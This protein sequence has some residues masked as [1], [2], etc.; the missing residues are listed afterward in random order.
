MNKKISIIVPCYNTEKYV[1][2]CLD[3]LI[4]QTY[5]NLEIIVVNDCSPGN[6]SEIVEEYKSNDDRIKIVNHKK[7]RGLFQARLSGSEIATG[8]YICFVDSDDYVDL[9]FY[10][11]MIF[12]A[13]KSKSDIVVCNTV[14]EERNRKFIY[15]LFKTGKT[16]LHE[17]EILDEYFKQEGQNYRWH[18]VWNKIYS[19]ELWKKCAPHYKIVDKHLIMTEDFM[20]STV[21]FSNAKK[22]TYNDNANYFYCSNDDASTS[23]SKINY[24]KAQKN[25]DDIVYSFEC[26]QNYLKKIKLFKKYKSNFINWRKLYADIWF[27]NITNSDMND[28][29]KEKLL[30]KLELLGKNNK[31]F[32]E[33]K[34]YSV[35]TNFNDKLLSLKK[36]IVNHDVISFDVFDTLVVRPFFEPV[37]LFRF[38]NKKY[39]ELFKSNGLLEFSTIRQNAERECRD[40]YYKKGIHEINL[41]Q[42]YDYIFEKYKLSKNKLNKIKQLEIE[43]EIRFCAKRETAYNLY[44]LARYLG[45]KVIITSD[46]YLSKDVIKKILQKNGYDYFDYYFVSNEYNKTKWTGELFDVV[47]TTINDN[48]LSYLHIGD[49]LQSDVESPRKLNFDAFHFP[50]T[51]D[52]FM[53]CSSTNI[54]NHC[55]RLFE[56]FECLHIDYGNYIDFLGNRCSMAIVANKFFDNPFVSFNENSDFN[57]DANFIGYYTLGMHTLA[58]TK[59][60]LDDVTEKSYDSLSFMARDGYIPYLAAKEMINLYNNKDLKMNYTYVSRKAIFPLS[61]NDFVDLYKF[62]EYYDMRTT[63]IEDILMLLKQILDLPNDYEKKLKENGYSKKQLLLT[64]DE[65]YNFMQFLYNNFYSIKKYKKNLSIAKKYFANEYNG[66]A[67]NFDIGYSGQPELVLSSILEKPIDTYFIHVNTDRGF[68]KSNYANYKLN[69]FYQFKPTFTGTLREYMI[70]SKSQS[71]I[72][73]YEK[74]D[75]VYPLLDEREIYSYF[76]TKILEEIQTGCIDFVKD[77]CLIFGK[78]IFDI[79]I[80]RFYMSAPYEYYL[81]YSKDIDRKIFNGLKFEN[82]V[83]DDLDML[84]FWSNRLKEYNLY[85]NSYGRENEL[86][87]NHYSVFLNSR[88]LHRNRLVRIIFY[89]LYD[90]VI[91]REKIKNRLDK[92]GKMYKILSKIYSKIK[93]NK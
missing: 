40:F 37:D 60:L 47:K 26:V 61:I 85:Y 78:D 52:V 81:C 72:G 36:E 32:V 21:I 71:C 7:N 10:R 70:S 24:N 12:T 88:V 39:M 86:G 6:I 19:M 28:E 77:F 76:D 45:K 57:C 43:L 18:T 8:D 67:S 1:E 27:H 84:K 49:N 20:Y 25:I 15:N 64:D 42:I 58:I 34:F 48:N 91:L 74:D 3:S 30:Q 14:V 4:N 82:N 65:Y 54:V 9:D 29:K 13:E 38:L 62:R 50:K 5:K 73:Y 44:E 23:V 56:N 92:D 69:C 66:K 16:E 33:E 35:T 87:I 53:N 89:L 51:M 83:G 55:G 41:D 90:R 68:T 31:D 79:D 22:L 80:E 63:T 46:M 75:N 2:R 93:R 59:W 17:S 11:E